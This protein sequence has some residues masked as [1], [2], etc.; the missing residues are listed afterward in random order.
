MD[1]IYTTMA[2]T[3]G[4]QTIKFSL[5]YN[6]HP[7]FIIV[8]EKYQTM[9]KEIYYGIPDMSSGRLRL[10]TDQGHRK[11]AND[12]LNYFL[13]Q[14]N[15]RFPHIE[16]NLLFN[17]LCNVDDYNHSQPEFFNRYA[18][19]IQSHI[20]R[21]KITA[22]TLIDIQ[23]SYFVKQH[24]PQLKVHAGVNMFIREA[25]Q[26]EYLEYF[27]VINFD[28]EI[29]RDLK[30]IEQLKKVA[31][32]KELKILLN[33]GCMARCTNR[34][35]CINKVSARN[36]QVRD[37]ESFNIC[38]KTFTDM[39]WAIL[40]SPIVR[41]EDLDKYSH[42]GISYW[43]LASRITPT[44]MIDE[45]LSGYINRRYINSLFY[46]V[47]CPSRW[48]LSKK[49][50]LYN[51]EIPHDFF[52]FVSHCRLN[53]HTCNYCRDLFQRLATIKTNQA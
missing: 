43:K 5:G 26:L 15:N 1:I 4:S 49:Y 13:T 23:L 42:L 8:V 45:I 30:S 41:P 51:N 20:D 46:L 50:N 18:A 6:N 39:P 14:M 11:Q 28:R 40:Q 27:D 37:E 35:Q 7:D 3:S 31:P 21:Y 53:C 32:H 22:V 36:Q 29:N 16:R 33:E 34:I 9:I 48:V 12:E 19:I 47:E 38:H 44:P 2:V 25:K 24:F 52:H 10:I 17:A